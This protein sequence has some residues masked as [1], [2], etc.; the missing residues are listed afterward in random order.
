MAAVFS[1]NSNHKEYAEESPLVDSSTNQIS[2]VAAV[3]NAK[4]STR[5][6]IRTADL[7]FKVKNVVKATYNIEDIVVKEGG[8]VTYTN[9]NSEIQNVNTTA[10]SRDSSLEITRFTVGNS[11]TLR[12]PNTKLDTVLKQIAK[13]VS[14]LDYRIIKAD[15]VALQI[16]GNQMTQNRALNHQERLSKAI[17]GRGKKLKETTTAEELLWNKQEQQDNAKMNNLRLKDQINFSTINI[18]IYQNPEI[19]RELV[20]NEINIKAYEPNFGIKLLEALQTGWYILEEFLLFLTR[21]W[22]I[23]L[24]AVIAYFLYKKFKYKI[25]G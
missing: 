17:D 18:S 25:K 2:S 1:C 24:L 19:K 3:E 10:L 4:D 12:V 16:I 7:K 14:F 13:N 5:K 15:D 21:I 9:L 22:T 11:I 20:E 23:L 6:F 8:F